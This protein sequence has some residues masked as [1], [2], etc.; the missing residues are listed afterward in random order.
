MYFVC[1]TQGQRANEHLHVDSN[2]AS[3]PALR[4]SAQLAAMRE[5]SGG[6][7]VVAGKGGLG[8]PLL[9]FGL[10]AVGLIAL[11]IGLGEYAH[12][13]RP[14][15]TPDNEYG[16]TPTRVCDMYGEPLIMDFKGRLWNKSTYSQ[17]DM[18]NPPPV[19][20]CTDQELYNNGLSPARAGAAGAAGAGTPY[21]K[22]ELRSQDFVSVDAVY[23]GGYHDFD[24]AY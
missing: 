6:A 12:P 22:R 15:T 17:V 7:G 9:K 2:R 18:N 16:L 21:Q 10:G 1:T 14:N 4:A 11:A 13:K 23:G 5:A 24:A 19:H 3:N 8:K 20:Q